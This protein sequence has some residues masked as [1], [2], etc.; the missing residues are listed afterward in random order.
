MELTGK[1]R[2]ITFAGRTLRLC[3]QKSRD[4]THLSEYDHNGSTLCDA[5]CGV[6]SLAHAVEWMH[7]VRLDPDAVADVAVAVGGRGDDGTDRPAMLQGMMENGFAARCGFRYEGDGLLNDTERLWRHMTS[8][9]AAL[10]NLRPGHIVALLAARERDGWREL[11]AM[12]S[13]AESASEK[14][15]DHVRAC[16]PG[17]EVI[18]PVRNTADETVGYAM[19]YALFWVDADLPKDFNLLYKTD[20]IKE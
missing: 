5:G 20:P 9:G 16:E 18:Y 4:W 19:S 11:L 1:T 15:R 12:D 7:G 8:G 17:S 10:C 2:E 13:V 3:N 14:I 6:F